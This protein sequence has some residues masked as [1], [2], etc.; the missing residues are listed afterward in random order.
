MNEVELCSALVRL[1]E[2]AVSDILLLDKTGTPRKIK[3][4]N[5]YLPLKNDEEEDFPYV[6]VRFEKSSTDWDGTESQVA[7]IAGTYC[8]GRDNEGIAG[9]KMQG[10]IDGL[11][12]LSMIR[13]EI[14]NLPNGVMENC[15]VVKSP[16]VLSD[17]GEQ[18]FPYWHCE[19][20]TS[21][22]IP[23]ISMNNIRAENI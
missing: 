16:I 17:P 20:T 1:V 14:M 22:V 5:G 19:M 6:L 4:F 23:F 12:V 3:V 2:K 15:F 10:F 18:E 7:I 8:E 21:W 9:N 13:S 11:N